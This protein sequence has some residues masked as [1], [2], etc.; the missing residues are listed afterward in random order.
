M[1]W[2]K[3]AKGFVGTPSET[4]MLALIDPSQSVHRHTCKEGEKLIAWLALAHESV[5]QRKKLIRGP[6]ASERFSVSFS[7]SDES[8]SCASYVLSKEGLP[9]AEEQEGG[10]Q[11]QSGEAKAAWVNFRVYRVFW[12]RV[13]R[14]E[15]SGIV[16]ERT[17]IKQD[18]SIA[19][20]EAS[21]RQMENHS[22]TLEKKYRN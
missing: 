8:Q 13:F 1:G 11:F 19:N 9:S 21:R 22:K 10:H 17:S 2:Q 16:A 20:T 4:R 18:L 5:R 15:G 6:N 3:N 12:F 14:V 7:S